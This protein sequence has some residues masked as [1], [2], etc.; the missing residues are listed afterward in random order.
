MCMYVLCV[1]RR[2]TNVNKQH[3]NLHVSVAKCQ[4]SANNAALVKCLQLLF[5][6]NH[7]SQGASFGVLF[8][9]ACACA[10]DEG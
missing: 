8:G 3:F 2:Q 7:F 6:E 9:G 1:L 10:H 5:K 4:G